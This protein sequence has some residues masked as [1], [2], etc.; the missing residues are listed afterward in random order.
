M[1]APPSG[2]LKAGGVDLVGLASL[3]ITKELSVFGKAGAVFASE[4]STLNANSL[5]TPVGTAKS[6]E[7]LPLV[8]AGVSYKLTQNIDLR[9]DYDHVSGLGKA[10]KT[11]EM[12][13]NMLS[14]GLGY[15]F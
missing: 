10:S 14:V 2:S 9:A 3:P 12:S 4:K 15:N 11:G 1:A 6:H 7:V 13:S 8:G 5:A